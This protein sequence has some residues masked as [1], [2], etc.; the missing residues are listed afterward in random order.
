MTAPARPR[1]DKGPSRIFDAAASLCRV[2][3]AVAA[4]GRIARLL[5]LACTLLGL[6]ALHTIGHAAVTGADH[7]AAAVSAADSGL[8]LIAAAPR[9]ADGCGNDGC[10]HESVMPGGAHDTNQ[11]WDVCVAVLSVLALGVLLAALLLIATRSR[12]PTPARRWPPRTS[13]ISRTP[14]FGL[15]LTAIAV[16]RT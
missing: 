2:E 1:Y 15:A 14:P 12:G 11:R 10:T 3:T 16:A 7:P 4:I 6:T 9:D 5:L 8:V 13:R